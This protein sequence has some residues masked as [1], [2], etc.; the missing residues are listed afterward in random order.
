ML[1]GVVLESVLQSELE[2]AIR[3][4]EHAQRG[5]AAAIS[6]PRDLTNRPG[7][8]KRAAELESSTL[9]DLWHAL[10]R[11]DNFNRHGSTSQAAP[12]SRISLRQ[13]KPYTEP[14]KGVRDGL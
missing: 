7:H 8:I 6:L 9:S 11:L 14:M 5:F 10:E 12:E 13:S 3:R 1:A 2:L 4:Y